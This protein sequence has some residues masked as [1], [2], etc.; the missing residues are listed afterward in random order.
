M[1]RVPINE[2]KLRQNRGHVVKK[3]TTNENIDVVC[4][5]VMCVRRVTLVQ[6]HVVD[7]LGISYGTVNMNL[8]IEL[9]FTCAV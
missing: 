1:C 8:H 9:K 5:I 6:I 4:D 3:V 7:T 2:C